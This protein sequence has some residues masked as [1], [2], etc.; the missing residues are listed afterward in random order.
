MSWLDQRGRLNAAIDTAFASRFRFEPQGR[1][2]IAGPGPDPDRPGGEIR[3]V[4]TLEPGL[5]RP[6]GVH[7]PARGKSALM[8]PAGRA[9][10]TCAPEAFAAEPKPGDLLRPL[11]GGYLWS[12][13][14]RISHVTHDGLRLRLRL[15]AIEAESLR[16]QAGSLRG[17]GESP[18]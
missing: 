1:P 7:A 17:Q 12:H 10:L 2:S 6:G 8:V 11:D 15:A 4:L 18:S 14:W 16:G 3:G 5:D 13:V 9:E